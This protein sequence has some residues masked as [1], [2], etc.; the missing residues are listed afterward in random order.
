MLQFTAPIWLYTATAMALPLLIHLWNLRKGKRL[1]IGSLLLITQSIQ[2]TARQLR[3]TEWL[4]L[5]LRCLLILLLSLLLAGAYWQNKAG[6]K[7]QKGWVLVPKESINRIYPAFK[8]KIDS[9]LQAGYQLHAFNFP[10]ET[11]NT[12]NTEIAPVKSASYW[13]RLAQLNNRLPAGFPVIVFSDGSLQY[14]TGNRPDISVALQWHTM[15]ADNDYTGLVRATPSGTDSIRLR[16][17]KTGAE[18]T[19]FTNVA[20]AANTPAPGI[21]I[22]Q[23]DSGRMVQ[24]QQQPAVLI[25]TNVLRITVYQ[26]NPQQGARYIIAALEA[27]RPMLDQPLQVS[28]VKDAASIP[29]NQ[30]WVFWLSDEPL[31]NI[32]SNTNYFVYEKGDAINKNSQL[33]TENNTSAGPGSLVIYKRVAS[34]DGAEHIWT[35]GSG[36]PILARNDNNHYR[37]YSRFDPSWNNLVWNAAFPELIFQLLQKAPDHSTTDLRQIDPVQLSF[38]SVAGT[39]KTTSLADRTDLSAICWWLL[40][41]CFVAERWLSLHPKTKKGAA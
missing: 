15:S 5:L 39:E 35:D 38:T 23:T 29:E 25:D 18:K 37:F 28:Q 3:I 11:I 41:L 31:S 12:N 16:F 9:L 26:K 27:I 13:Q 1:K 8:A 40:L 32:N 36:Q 7:N 10:F 6:G 34:D 24:W 19:V 20:V 17:F 4:L 22:R 33:I 21:Q 2:P 30:D 14:F